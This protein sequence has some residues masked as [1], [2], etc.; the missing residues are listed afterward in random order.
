MMFKGTFFGINDGGDYGWTESVYVDRDDFSTAATALLAWRDALYPIMCDNH[1]YEA[2]RISKVGSPRVSQLSFLAPPADGVRVDTTMHASV[3]PNYALL[4]ARNDLDSGHHGHRW[5]HGV[6]EYLFTAA[7]IYDSGNPIA[8]A[9]TTFLAA[10]A[11]TYIRYKKVG[12]PPY[13]FTLATNNF[14]VRKSA[15]KVGRPFGLA[16]GR[17]RIA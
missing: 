1:F 3:D 10:D 7:Q 5:L 9:V 11:T 16:T 12:D 14:A 6:P 15:R 8:A 13:A 17:R 2:L 4:V